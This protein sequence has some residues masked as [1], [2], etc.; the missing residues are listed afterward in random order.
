MTFICEYILST[1]SHTVCKI[2]KYKKYYRNF[3]T[4]GFRSTF[5]RN[6]N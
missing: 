4:K 6:I 3:T 5:L 1:L 2:R